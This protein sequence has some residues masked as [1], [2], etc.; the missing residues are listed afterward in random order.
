MTTKEEIAFF[1]KM[2]E[3]L[4]LHEA[5]RDMIYPDFKNVEVRVQK[6]QIVFSNMHNF[7]FIWLLI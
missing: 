3:A 6:S 2:P 7:T 4:P 1:D 5:F